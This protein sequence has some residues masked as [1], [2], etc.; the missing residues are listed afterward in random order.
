MTNDGNTSQVQRLQKGCTIFCANLTLCRG[1]LVSLNGPYGTIEVAR[2]RSM[3]LGHRYEPSSGS[4]GILS[5]G[6]WFIRLAT[7]S[8]QVYNSNG[9]RTCSLIAFFRA[10]LGRLTNA[11]VQPFWCGAPGCNELPSHSFL[12]AKFFKL[13][14]IPPLDHF[15]EFALCAH[16]LRTVITHHQRRLSS[17]SKESS[18][19]LPKFNWRIIYSQL[20][21]YSSR[22]H[23]GKDYS[24]MLGGCVSAYLHFVRSKV[25]TCC[26]MKRGH[27]RFKASSGQVSHE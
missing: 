24:I 25:V 16:K 12:C 6:R 10:F 22:V 3:W 27:Q 8:K 1:F 19:H 11:S 21:V 20:Q 23:A 9:V 18:Q 17:D 26:V 4:L 13:F 15:S 5:M 2:P 7:S 14:M